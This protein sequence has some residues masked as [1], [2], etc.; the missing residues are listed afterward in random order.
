MT[1]PFSLIT[2]DEWAE[3]YW[4]NATGACDSEARFRRGERRPADAIAAAARE[5]DRL[6]AASD[7]LRRQ[8][9]YEFPDES[10]PARTGAP[11]AQ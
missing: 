7:D 5:F 9:P 11:D 2:R 10:E 1:R 8:L 3:Y 4:A 6:A